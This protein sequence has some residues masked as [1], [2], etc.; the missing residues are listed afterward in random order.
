MIGANDNVP[1]A[2][3]NELVV[4]G[5]VTLTA[6]LSAVFR[7]AEKDIAAVLVDKAGEP[8]RLAN[9]DPAPNTVRRREGQ[10][11]L[12]EI[13]LAITEDL[14][15]KRMQAVRTEIAQ[16]EKRRG[17]EITE[18]RL[19][20]RPG[21]EG[22]EY[23]IRR[24]G[25]STLASAGG[26]GDPVETKRLMAAALRYRADHERIDP[27]SRLTPPTLMREGRGGGGDGYADKVAQSWDRV[28]AIHLMIAGVEPSL[29]PTRRPNM[30]N[31]PARH[32][33]MQ[34]IWVLQ[35]VAGKGA[36]LRELSNSGSVIDRMSKQLVQALGVAAVVYGL[37]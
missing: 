32:P 20:D 14:D 1:G 12:M 3:D 23:R 17:Y 15:A 5:G 22:I 37:D 35:E 2:N 31:L 4:V 16:L 8:V 9:G 30:P 28:R 26:L 21:Q 24:D 19:R 13:E 18:T 33:A 6:R 11:A 34:A 25:L 7:R 29:D 27:E 10:Q 36:N